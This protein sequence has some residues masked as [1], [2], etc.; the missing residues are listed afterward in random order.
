MNP[1]H[2]Q[3][4]YAARR[5]ELRRKLFRGRCHSNHLSSGGVMM[6][7]FLSLREL[8]VNPVIT[9]REGRRIKADALSQ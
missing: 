6:R 4:S 1:G 9:A 8:C 5:F 2:E 3:R 7:I